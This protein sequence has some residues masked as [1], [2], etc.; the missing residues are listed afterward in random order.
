[1]QVKT[2]LFGQP[3]RHGRWTRKKNVNDQNWSRIMRE[4]YPIWRHHIAYKILGA[5][6]R[7]DAQ[8]VVLWTKRIGINSSWQRHRLNGTSTIVARGSIR[9][10]DPQ[11]F[12]IAIY[13]RVVHQHE[14]LVCVD[15]LRSRRNCRRRTIKRRGL[16]SVQGNAINVHV[17]AVQSNFD[18]FPINRE[19]SIKITK[20]RPT[21]ESGIECA[22][23][24]SSKAT[25]ESR[26]TTAIACP[27]TGEKWIASPTWYGFD[28]WF[29]CV[30][31]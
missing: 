23:K 14:F 30:N 3:S 24:L 7:M 5:S 25:T 9:Y 22:R 2:F 19:N 17:L 12:R 1:M 21:A 20:F 8:R 13:S 15:G 4:F 10:S 18:C 26:N 29:W 28:N 16:E 27:I 6:A 11:L 31:I